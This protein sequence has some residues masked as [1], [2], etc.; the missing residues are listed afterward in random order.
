MLI[1]WLCDI[2]SFIIVIRYINWIIHDLS[3]GCVWNKSYV[4]WY[5]FVEFLIIY[6]YGVTY[7]VIITH[8]LKYDVYADRLNI[9]ICIYIISLLKLFSTIYYTIDMCQLHFHM[10][11]YL[12]LLNV[13]IFLLF[14]HHAN[15][16]CILATQMYPY[17]N[18]LVRSLADVLNWNRYNPFWAV[19]ISWMFVYILIFNAAYFSQR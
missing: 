6:L 13:H 17:N 15:W 9:Y 7:C 8:L 5:V 16:K 12:Y 2:K 10:I 1:D 4:Y 18:Q 11:E 14:S 3:A 19:I